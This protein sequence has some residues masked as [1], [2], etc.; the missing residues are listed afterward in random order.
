MSS[1]NSC[2]EGGEHIFS[3]DEE[4]AQKKG[5]E[6]PINCEKCGAVPPRSAGGIPVSDLLAAAHILDLHAK[7]SDPKAELESL[8]KSRETAIRWALEQRRVFGPYGQSN[9]QLPPAHILAREIGAL[10]QVIGMCL[11]VMTPGMRE[12]VIESLENLSRGP[13]DT[14]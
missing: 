4:Y 12:T 8:R 10:R 9:D 7:K 14:A 2:P 13:G 6:A 3:P 5:V 11:L 1:N